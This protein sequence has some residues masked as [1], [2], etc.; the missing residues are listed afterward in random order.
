[1]TQF[2]RDEIIDEIAHVIL[3]TREFVGNENEAAREFVRESV[4][5]KEVHAK[6][7]RIAKFRAN[8]IWNGWQ[9]EAGAPEKHLF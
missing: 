5:P 4:L 9:R 2:I 8:K 7:I 1:M 3:T 6:A